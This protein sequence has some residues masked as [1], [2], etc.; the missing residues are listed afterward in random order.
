MNFLLGMMNTYV[1]ET[2]D[3]CRKKV[4]SNPGDLIANIKK[5]FNVGSHEV[6]IQTYGPS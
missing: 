2:K 3:G 6:V 5:K 1:V 4:C